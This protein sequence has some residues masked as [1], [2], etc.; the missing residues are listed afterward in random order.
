M[1]FKITYMNISTN[2]IELIKQFEEFVSCPYVDSVGKLTI[3]YGTTYYQNGNNVQKND[4]CI[5]EVQATSI[6]ENYLKGTVEFL[7]SVIKVE[8]NQNQFDSLCSIVYNIGVGNFSHST[9][10]REVNTDSSNPSIRTDFLMF[11]KGHENGQLVVLPGL[12]TRR[13]K[14]ADLYFKV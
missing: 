13:S 11:N 14:E 3:G 9:L 8:L 10:L 2:G 6:L 12:T 5:T 1:G 4:P 7:N